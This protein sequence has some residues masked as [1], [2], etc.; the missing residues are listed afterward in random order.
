MRA[1]LA[2]LA[3]S[4]LA[5]TAAQAAPAPG[6]LG[7]KG[8]T[9]PHAK[10]SV[11]PSSIVVACADAGFYFTKLKWSA[12]QPRSASATGLANQNDCTP[13]CAAGRFHT[14]RA[15]IRLSAPAACHGHRVF[16]RIAWTYTGTRPKGVA[17]SGSQTFGCA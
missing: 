12:W 9:S 11:R 5:A 4:L 1:L 7:C 13:N 3:V 6:F 14:Y 17:R 10:P 2:A 16:M 15:R 8:F